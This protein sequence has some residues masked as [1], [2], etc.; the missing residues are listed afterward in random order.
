MAEPARNLDR[1]LGIELPL[2]V[3][4]AR[5]RMSLEEV[6]K[7]VPGTVLDFEKAVTEPLD[8]LVNDKVIARGDTVKVGERFGLQVREIAAPKET[9][10]A[11]GGP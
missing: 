10:R 4:L 11:M 9:I 3:L 8:L 5:K 7:L 6:L 2:V 1:V